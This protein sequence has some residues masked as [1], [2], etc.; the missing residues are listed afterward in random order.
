MGSSWMTNAASAISWNWNFSPGPR[1]SREGGHREGVTRRNF[2]KVLITLSS[3]PPVLRPRPP[4]LFPPAPGHFTLWARLITATWECRPGAARGTKARRGAGPHT[5]RRLPSARLPALGCGRPAGTML[6]R[7]LLFP[8]LLALAGAFPTAA[9]DFFADMMSTTSSLED[10]ATEAADFFLDVQSTT[11]SFEDKATGATELTTE[12]SLENTKGFDF[13]PDAQFTT[14]S[15]E[16]QATESAESTTEDPL[17]NT[18]GFDFFP[19]TQFT[20]SSF[21]DEA[22]GAT[23]S[24]TEDPLEN[25]KGFDFFPDAHFTTSSFEDEDTESTDFFS[26]VQS[27]TSSFEDKAT[28]AT[29]SA[30]EYPMNIL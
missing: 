24:T 10:K 3:K 9:P 16:D 15:F 19:D 8:S 27:T 6:G 14:S 23:E 11:S 25:T 22:S 12:E 13:F 29:E 26:D 2:S 18:K 17:E 7:A 1:R 21:E 28:E 30:T 5:L 20:T 4:S